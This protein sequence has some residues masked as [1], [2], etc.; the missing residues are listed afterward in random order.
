VR[1]YALEAN[2]FIEALLKI[3]AQFNVPLGV[4]WIKTANTL[5]PVRLSR[6]SATVGDIIDSLL[7]MQPGYEWRTEVGV[8]HVFQRDLVSDTRNPLNIT[9]KSFEQ[10]PQSVGFANAV[11]DQMVRYPGQNGIS[12]SVLGYPGE[13]AF[14][15]AAQNIPARNIMNRIVT[16]GL[17]MLPQPPP[18][19]NRIWI[20]TFP[21]NQVLGSDGYF[22]AV[23]VWNP[24]YVAKESQ[25]IWILLPWGYPPPENMVK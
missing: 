21:E 11:L 7:S 24:A 18:G 4:E 14:S 12:V 15:F 19:M 16:S 13:P 17:Q 9:I 5:Q 1:N 20:A 3:S 8:I 25:P 2:S 10:K 23:P 22:E 6:S